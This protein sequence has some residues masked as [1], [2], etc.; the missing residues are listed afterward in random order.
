MLTPWRIE[1][2]GSTVVVRT[3]NN[4][5]V[6][7]TYFDDETLTRLQSAQGRSPQAGVAISRLPELLGKAEPQQ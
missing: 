2:G 3:A 7:V 5:V 4:F 6:S 1:E